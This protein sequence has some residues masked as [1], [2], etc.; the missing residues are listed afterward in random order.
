MPMRTVHAGYQI[1]GFR[2]GSFFRARV[3]RKDGAPIV[4][5]GKSGV[6][7]ETQQCPEMDIAIGQAK[8]AI[9]T[10]LIR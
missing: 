1:E 3:R 4:S 5:P 9:D 10:G 2:D 7:W 6:T 8:Y